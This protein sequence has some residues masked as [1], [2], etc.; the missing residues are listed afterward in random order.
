MINFL[1]KLKNNLI[2]FYKKRNMK[3]AKLGVTYSL[4][5]GEEI[6]SYSLK[7]I[8]NNVDYINVVYQKK[9]WTG[10]ECSMNLED[11]LK[12]LIAEGL[13]DNII[14]YKVPNNINPNQ[15]TKLVLEK[16]NIGLKDLKRKKCTHCMIMDVD[17]LF[18]SVE[19][20][21][22][23]KFVIENNISHSACNLYDYRY[24]PEIRS[25][26]AAKYS[27]PF[28][29]KLRFWSKISE[30]FIM[31][32]K[33]DR[34]RTISY[35]KLLDKFYFLNNV[36]MHHMTGLRS[37]Y[38]KK[39]DSTITNYTYNGK[40]I[41]DDARKKYEIEQKLSIEELTE[42]ENSQYIKV[43]NKFNIKLSDYKEDM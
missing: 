39:L 5:N 4:F 36:S 31:P 40:S 12:A 9:S 19:F 16:K 20:F 7:C 34:L 37:D 33:V 42:L 15:K 35:W 27:V 11:K 24:Y 2:F 32:V 26:D 14:E 41:V 25:R 30:H 29:F 28:I 13:I 1:K 21:D 17:E 3:K 8:R 22:A 10:T 6:L 23:K 38:L 18:D 43:E